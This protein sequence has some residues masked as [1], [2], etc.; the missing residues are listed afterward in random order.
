[1][2][3][4]LREK[5]K[6]KIRLRKPTKK[7][8]LRFIRNSLLVI[9]G[10]F[11][12]AIG[13]EM[14]VIPANLDVG[15]V[16]GIAV[17]FKYRNPEINT[18]VIITIITWGL[19]LVGLIILGWKFSLQTL[20]ST[21]F[22]PLFLFALQYLV[23]YVPWLSIFNSASLQEQE[24]LVLLLCAVFG[25]FLIGTGCAITFLGGGSTGGVD[26]ITFVLCKFFKGIK[27]TYSIFTVDAI[28]VIAGFFANPNHDLALTLEGVLCAFIS[29]LVIDKIFAGSSKT[30]IAYVVTDKYEQLT[31]EIIN[32]VDR[33]T[34]IVDIEGGYSKEKKKAV[35]ISFSMREYN[36]IRAI[37]ASLDKKAFMT[38]NQAHEINGEGFKPF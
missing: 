23:K 21:I 22:Y 3:K 33:T 2:V 8:V 18:E 24:G 1:M 15:G 12:L 7:D 37:V 16:A 10:T 20:I 29:S 34:S 35:I 25:G 17:C 11:I 6:N 13:T 19:F 9:L 38:I 36:Q 30:Y 28:V 14:F 27:S 31:Q 5:L 4:L 26:V 32:R